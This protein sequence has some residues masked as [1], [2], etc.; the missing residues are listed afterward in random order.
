MERGP[1]QLHWLEAGPVAALLLLCLAL[2]MRPETPMSYFTAASQSLYDVN[3]YIHTVAVGSGM[4]K[5]P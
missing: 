1:P 3:A 4:E 5:T 2:S